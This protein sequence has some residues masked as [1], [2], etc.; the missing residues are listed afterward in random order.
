MCNRHAIILLTWR[1]VAQMDAMTKRMMNQ[2][3]NATK[4]IVCQKLGQ[5]FDHQLQQIHTP[6]NVFTIAKIDSH[7]HSNNPMPSIY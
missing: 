4:I 2:M 1:V 7:A 3:A 6:S 5:I